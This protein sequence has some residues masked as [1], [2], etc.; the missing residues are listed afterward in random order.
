MPI[1][2]LFTTNHMAVN[3]KNFHYKH[4]KHQL[5]KGQGVYEN[6]SFGNV[7]QIMY[8]N[9]IDATRRKQAKYAYSSVVTN[10]NTH[11]YKCLNGIFWAQY[12]EERLTGE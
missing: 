11:Q 4:I 9:A 10:L 5:Y 2:I 6:K 1:G 8:V 12:A 3:I 7:H